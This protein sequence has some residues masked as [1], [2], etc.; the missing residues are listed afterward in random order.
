MLRVD[1]FLHLRCEVP[2][3]SVVEEATELIGR[4]RRAAGL[5]DGPHAGPAPVPR[6]AASCATITAA[7]RG[8]LTDAEL[9]VLFERRLAYAG[10]RHAA[11]ELPRAGRARARARHT[12]GE[13]RRHD[14]PSMSPTP[15]AR[16]RRDRRIPDHRRSRARPAPGRH[17][18]ADGRAQSR[19]RRLAFRQRAD[20]RARSRRGARHSVVRLRAV[21]P[22]D[23]GAAAC[24]RH[25][26]GDSICRR[27]C[28]P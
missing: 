11:D 27:R 15:I 19:A 16:P 13:P 3:P 18:R 22:A 9:D 14:A 23:G 7:S 24:P 21:E 5:A 26:P 1:H 4:A 2:M 17:R 10:R 25:A 28:A 20:R 8:G 6:R 12:A